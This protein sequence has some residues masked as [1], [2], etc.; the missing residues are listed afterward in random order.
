MRVRRPLHASSLARM[1]VHRRWQPEGPS[2]PT[3]EIGAFGE[4]GK[5]LTVPAPWIRVV[6]GTEIV[7]SIRND[8]VAMLVFMVSARAAARQA[9]RSKC[10]PIRHG[11]CVSEAVLPELPLLGLDDRRA[12]TVPRVRWADLSST[13]QEP[14]NQIASC[15]HRMDGPHGRV[16]SVNHGSVRQIQASHHFRD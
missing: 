15:D 7:A 4:V 9:P 16:S 5:A 11:R 13:R 6:E 3:L 2:G 14:S 8:R 1:G 12:G 10:R